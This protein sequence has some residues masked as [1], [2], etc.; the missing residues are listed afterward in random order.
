[1][2]KACAYVLST[3]F[4]RTWPFRLPP[5]K[6]CGIWKLQLAGFFYFRTQCI[7]QTLEAPADF[8]ILVPSIKWEH[9]PHTWTL[10]RI[11]ARIKLYEKGNTSLNLLLE[12]SFGNSTRKPRYSPDSGELPNVATNY[13]ERTEKLN[14][15]FSLCLGRE[16]SGGW[17][18]HERTSL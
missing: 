14:S 15:T 17:V 13:W 8:T 7:L 3:Y 1:M 2:Y 16:L 10:G 6:F 12:L 9:T 11:A 4:T 18:V 5:R